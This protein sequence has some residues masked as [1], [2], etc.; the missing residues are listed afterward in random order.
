MA[1]EPHERVE[2]V[3]YMLRDH[4]EACLRLADVLDDQGRT[5]SNEER[6]LIRTVMVPAIQEDY[7]TALT[8]FLVTGTFDLYVPYTE[9]L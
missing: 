4:A 3:R 8:R 6:R 2:Q 9:G 7:E 5:M 1:K